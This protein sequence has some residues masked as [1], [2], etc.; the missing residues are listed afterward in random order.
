MTTRVVFFF[1]FIVSLIFY[2]VAHLYWNDKQ[3]TFLFGLFLYSL[4]TPTN[5]KIE[6]LDYLYTRNKHVCC[7]LELIVNTD[8]EYNERERT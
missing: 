3:A 1:F 8:K 7:R 2:E 4:I 5:G 6:K